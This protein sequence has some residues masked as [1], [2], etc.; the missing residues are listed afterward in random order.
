LRLGKCFT[1]PHAAK[2]LDGAVLVLKI[3]KPL[4]WAGTTV[5]IQ[6]AFPGKAK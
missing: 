4:G 2:A 5:T 3:A 6:L 1:A